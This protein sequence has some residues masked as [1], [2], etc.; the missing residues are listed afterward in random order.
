MALRPKG[1]TIVDPTNRR[2]TRI[3]HACKNRHV[4]TRLFFFLLSLSLLFFYL[5]GWLV[6]SFFVDGD[7]LSL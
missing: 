5:F 7:S 1:D 2:V 3:T 6:S 4:Y